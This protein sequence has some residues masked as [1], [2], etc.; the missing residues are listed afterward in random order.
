MVVYQNL[1]ECL[2]TLTSK[3]EHRSNRV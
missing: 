3:R 1:S 2:V